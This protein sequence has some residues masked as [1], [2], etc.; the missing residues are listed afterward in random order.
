MFRQATLQRVQYA[1]QMATQAITM[2]EKQVLDR[3]QGDS[4]AQS[5]AERSQSIIAL[6]SVMLEEDDRQ[7]RTL[8]VP[9]TTLR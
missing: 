6:A 2:Q 4:A 3:A 5:F 8:I 9:P 7:Q 1:L